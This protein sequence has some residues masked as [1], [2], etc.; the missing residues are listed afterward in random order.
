MDALAARVIVIAA[1][2][3][4]GKF[5]TATL[6]PPAVLSV[7]VSHAV[8]VAVPPTVALA[9]STFVFATV[10]VVLLGA[11]ATVK[12]PLYTAFEAP[13]IVT[14]LPATK[15]CA[16]AVVIVATFDA[17]AAVVIVAAVCGVEVLMYNFLL[18]TA[19]MFSGNMT[20]SADV[21]CTPTAPGNGWKPIGLGAVLSITM[22]LLRL[23]EPVAPDAGTG[24]L[25]DTPVMV[26]PF[27]CNPVTLRRWLGWVTVE[28]VAPIT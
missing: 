25:L 26:P 22:F 17:N 20:V 10:N 19:V 4:F 1:P 2:P 21:A 28:S 5:D 12:S 16:A 14:A 6:P 23:S 15:P 7:M 8:R 9:T 24:G 18:L 11:E 27:N 3:L 13:A